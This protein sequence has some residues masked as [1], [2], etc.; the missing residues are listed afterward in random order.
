MV[1]IQHE[2]TQKEQACY[3]NEYLLNK[4][5]L[6]KYERFACRF[7][8]KCKSKNVLRDKLLVPVVLLTLI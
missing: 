4:P 5:I 1:Y 8:L 6:I 2:K 7:R 3:K